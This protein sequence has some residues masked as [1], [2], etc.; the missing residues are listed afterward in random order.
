MEQPQTN[1]ATVAAEF[2]ACLSAKDSFCN[3]LEAIADLLPTAVDVRD[4]LIIARNIVPVVKRAH[5]FEENVVYPLVLSDSA[6]VVEVA[7]WIER[8]K[9]EHL[10]DEDFANDLCLAL[11]EFATNRNGANV[12][13]LSFLRSS[14]PPRRLRAHQPLAL[15]GRPGG[16][17]QFAK[18][19][20][21]RI[22]RCACGRK[23]SP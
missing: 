22:L 6:N 17:S 19:A 10:G 8:L 11:R 20:G 21:I 18:E 9:F 7:V 13:S 4:C 3:Q 23:V 15:A 2:R 12:E 5:A 16:V 1:R 14:P